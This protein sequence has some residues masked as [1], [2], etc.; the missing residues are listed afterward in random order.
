MS[1]AKKFLFNDVSLPILFSSIFSLSDFDNLSLI[2]PYGDSYFISFK[3]Y[4]NVS[5]TTFFEFAL[6]LVSFIALSL[7]KSLSLSEIEPFYD[8]F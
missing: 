6:T 7:N 8:F 1:I 4:P 3:Y 2:F 5:I